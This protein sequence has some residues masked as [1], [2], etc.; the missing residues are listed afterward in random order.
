MV[1][2]NEPF[3]KLPEV[4][5]WLPGKSDRDGQWLPAWRHMLDTEQVMSYLLS[6]WIPQGT[7][8]SMRGNLAEE[9]FV[10]VARFAALVHDIGKLTP[11]FLVKLLGSIPCEVKERLSGYGITISLS[12]ASYNDTAHTITGAA[13]LRQRNCPHSL[14]S[15]VS[16]HHGKPISEQEKKKY[17]KF[18]DKK[19]FS[20]LDYFGKQG[21]SSTEGQ[22]WDSA[23]ASWLHFSLK[24]C[25]YDSMEQ[26]PEIS[27]P[28]QLFLCALLI[29]ADWIASNSKYFPLMA[30]EESPCFSESRARIKSAIR[31][32]NLPECWMPD[33]TSM[34]K[35]TFAER[36]G[37][38]PNEVQR[39]VVEAVHQVEKPGIFILEAQM[40][41]GKTE[42][43][44]AAAELLA[45][46][47][48]ASGIFFGLPTQATANGIFPRITEWAV[49]QSE[50]CANAIQLAH[51]MAELNEQYQELFH[52]TAIS[53]LIVHPWFNGRKKALL[54]D[55]VI[56]TVDQLLMASLKMRHFM[57]RHLGLVSKVVIIDECHAYD[58]YM[59]V[60]LERTLRW[61]GQYGVPVILL[62]AT[63]PRERRI[64]LVDAYLGKHPDG[65]WQRNSA[66]PLLTWT[67]GE[68]VECKAIPLTQTTPRSVSVQ[69]L[70]SS[71][72][73]NDGSLIA[74]WLKDKLIDGGC[75]VVVANTVKRAQSIAAELRNQFP[76]HEVLL[77]HAQYM[78]EDRAAWEKDLTKRIGK[79]ST[80]GDRD[81]L[82]VV[83]TQV[84]EQS[85][86]IDADVM[87]SDLCP[88]DLLLQRI[89]RL[90]RHTRPRPKALENPL[91]AV[92]LS[93]DG[94]QEEGAEAIYGEWLLERT[95]VALPDS[96]ELPTNIPSLVEE[97]YM[98]PGEDLKETKSYHKYSNNIKNKISSA[99]TFLLRKPSESK[100]PEKNTLDGMLE[101]GVLG[102]DR[103]A[104]ARVRDGESTLEVLLMIR[105]HD[106]RIGF[107]PWHYN[108]ASFGFHQHL[109]SE[110]A[111]Q[112][113][114]Q[115]IRL[116]MAVSGENK[117][118]DAIAELERQTL[119]FAE[120]WMDVPQL[121]GELFLFLDENCCAHLNG[122]Q[123]S[124]DQKDGLQY[125]KE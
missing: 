112:I 21:Q 81:K 1:Y 67:D 62:S 69:K 27:I 72:R 79:L 107:V 114:R 53:D 80:K 101:D 42:A 100:R 121:N 24:Q 74:S 113:A 3:K 16:S 55:F 49:Q 66:Y 96:I 7:L 40:G 51:G 41:V 118:D 91:C 37:F 52:G 50:D 17:I 97:V 86:D 54:A 110:E 43:A 89:G 11:V 122:Y 34:N 57:L 47:K 33:C 98:A 70:K 36:F 68:N 32:L 82:I 12:A 10:R 117:V 58:A 48:G 15:I 92:L 103:L 38:F 56:G 9:E 25:G 94:S 35:E 105:Y 61:L 39:C 123:I 60:Y 71:N 13:F 59:N 8:Q 87:L 84:L 65:D 90:H 115:R 28:S 108:G 109:C 99:E 104:E 18:A 44:L 63:L 77:V 85:L 64:A 26:I 125:R 119:A 76:D 30:P 45:F 73:D 124:Y 102:N 20:S 88:M 93:E 111:L 46:K 83:G 78:M 95:A 2:A 106:N 22:I 116:P 4:L 6:K 120:E 29:M 75:A 5:L 31:E 19:Y 23:R 14:A